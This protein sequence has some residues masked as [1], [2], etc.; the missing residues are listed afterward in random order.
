MPKNTDIVIRDVKLT[1]EEF[2]YRTALKFGGVVTTH[3]KLMNITVTVEDRN[4]QTAKGFG[5][6]PLGNA[7]SFPSK[8]VSFDESLDA[9]VRLAGEIANKTAQDN[10]PAHPVD[11]MA[12][13]EPE[14]LEL[15][16]QVTQELSLADPIPK[17]CTLV[18]ASPV[19]AALHDAFGKAAGINSYDGLGRD[20]MNHS[21]EIY[22][23]EDFEGEYLDKY[24]SRQPKSELPL[25]HLVGAL[26]PLT[27]ADIDQR[28]DDGLPELSLIHI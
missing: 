16:N 26:D 15:A 14:F 6:M 5:S 10:V 12:R 28:L 3:C 9:M 20:H 21:L 25:Y 2:P 27:D 4:G 1:F 13:L 11:I 24:T 7:W 18:T 19:D 22:L 23:N 17:L 8:K